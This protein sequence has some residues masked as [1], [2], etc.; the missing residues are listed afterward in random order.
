ML[1]VHIH[2]WKATYRAEVERRFGLL[3][4]SISEF[5]HYLRHKE[6][7]NELAEK[8][9]DDLLWYQHN[10]DVD[11]AL[12]WMYSFL[13]EDWRFIDKLEHYHIAGQEDKV[14]LQRLKNEEA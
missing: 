8:H 6:A 10:V 4:D 7:I 12:R 3:K 2:R 13:V 9:R 1:I 14:A 11:E 5:M